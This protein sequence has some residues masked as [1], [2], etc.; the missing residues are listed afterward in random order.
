M[1]LDWQQ[2]LVFAVVIGVFASFVWGRFSIELVALAGAG[3]D[4]GDL[5]DNFIKNVIL[6]WAT[7]EGANSYLWQCDSDNNFGSV[8]DGFEG[9]T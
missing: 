3:A 7:L 6:D 2:T 1:A 4:V 8:P 9:T 5:S